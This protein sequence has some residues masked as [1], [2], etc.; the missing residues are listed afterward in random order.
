MTDDELLEELHKRILD[1]DS[2][3]TTSRI[4][5]NFNDYYIFESDEDIDQIQTLSCSVGLCEFEGIDPKHPIMFAAAQLAFANP[6][7]ITQY[8]TDLKD[9]FRRAGITS[10]HVYN[11]LALIEG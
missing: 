9:E 5:R 10:I 6:F 1:D 2:D 3:I 11:Q 4:L 8:L 7:N